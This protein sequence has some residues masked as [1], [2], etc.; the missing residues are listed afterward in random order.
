[1]T[2]LNKLKQ[3]YLGNF[4]EI[5]YRNTSHTS[6]ED[7]LFRKW[8]D[9]DFDVFLPSIGKNLQRN[10]VWE[11]SQKEE[12]IRSIIIGRKIPDVTIVSY[13]NEKD[14]TTL[15]VIDGKQRLTTI[16][17][18][19]NNDFSVDGYYYKDFGKEFNLLLR[20]NAKMYYSYFDDKITDEQKIHLFKM[21]N[22]SGTPQDKNHLENLK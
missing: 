14:I 11:I 21:I 16:I 2:T 20:I 3:Q 6:I 4:T 5:P 13:T 17:S 7:Y 12:L 18:F 9:F 8:Y 10:L 22:F 19:I 1:M 15:Q